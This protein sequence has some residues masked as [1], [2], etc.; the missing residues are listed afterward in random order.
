[1][2]ANAAIL[3]LGLLLAAGCATPGSPDCYRSEDCPSGQRCDLV[4]GACL[5]I[6]DAGGEL[7]ASLDDGGACTTTECA[8]SCRARGY[9]D[10][11]ACLGTTCQ[12][13]GTPTDGGLE[14]AAET[15]DVA[16]DTGGCDLVE[17]TANCAA[18]GLAGECRTDG[19]VCTGG[20]DADADDG[21]RD[22]AADEA[23]TDEGGADDSGCPP[24]QSWCSGGCVDTTTSPLHCGACGRA[25]RTDQVC[26]GGACACATGFTECSGLCR[27]VRSDPSNCGRCG[28]VCG[29]GRTCSGGSCVCSSGLTDCGG[30][31]VDVLTDASNCGWCG[32]RC[33]CGGCS[34]GSCASSGGSASF[35]FPE[36]GDLSYIGSDPYMWQYGD[37]HQGTRSTSLACASSVSFTL[38]ADDNILWGDWLSL[39]VSIN[40]LAVGDFEFY[41]GYYVT[42]GS[43]SFAPIAGPTYTIRLEVTRTVLPGDGSVAISRGLSSW[44]LM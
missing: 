25:C 21:T 1:M 40:G 41:E 3:C 26:A 16:L 17:C 8:A 37:Y 4:T 14:D 38:Y 33:T 23:R 30:S 28:N 15:P 36:W 5:P 9:P 29:G 27:D 10:G 44:T 12:C 11:G 34:S 22:D 32:N 31:C 42:S 7:D 39:R 13:V 35:T 20:A 6:V 2:R 24:G 43:F 18:F 19:C